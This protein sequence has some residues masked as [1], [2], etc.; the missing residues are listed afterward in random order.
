MQ[1]FLVQVQYV[2]CL[3]HLYLEYTC[4]MCD[5]T[6]T[7]KGSLTRHIRSAHDGSRFSCDCGSTFGRRDNMMDHKKRCRGTGKN[8][9]SVYLSLL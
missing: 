4:G 8:I 9:L 6:Y 7:L 5:N 3:L 1:R 2:I